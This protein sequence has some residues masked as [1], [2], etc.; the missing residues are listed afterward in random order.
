MAEETATQEATEEKREVPAKFK[1]LID[2]VDKLSV[3]ELSE[4]V[5][6]L[7]DHYG[8]SAAAPMAVAAAPAAGGGDEAGSADEKSAYTVVL[9][10][11]GDQKINV[12]KAVRELTGLGLAESKAIVDGAP[13]PIKENVPKAE[14]DEAKTALEAAGAS[15][16]LQ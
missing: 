4:L 14:A 3:L 6:V 13:K 7:E 15:V 16:E 9:S 8:V 1:D 2:Q 5:K 10:S 12:I 11:A